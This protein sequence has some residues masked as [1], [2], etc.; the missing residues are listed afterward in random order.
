[1]E[2]GISDNWI[3]VPAP[4]E[5]RRAALD[6]VLRPLA[7]DDRPRVIDQTLH[8]VA[9][10]TRSLDGLLIAR[11]GPRL[12]GAV[13]AEIQP[14]RTAG[15]W[16]PQVAAAAS[17]AIASELLAHAAAY[18]RAHRVRM[19]QA[20]LA[21]D[22]SAMAET[23]RAADFEHLTDLLYLVSG[24][25]Q[26]PTAPVAS[27]LTF[28]PVNSESE[29]RLAA[30]VEATYLQTLDCPRLNGL[31]ECRDVLAGYRDTAHGDTSHWFLVRSGNCDVG[32]LLLARHAEI[33]TWEVIY[34]G[35][36][37]AARGA[38]LGAEVARQ[39]Q[40]LVRAAGGDRLMLAVDAANEPAIKT[41][42][43]AGF[44]TFDRRRVFVRFFDG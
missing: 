2:P 38:G 23:L 27:G 35:L 13:W 30:I 26:F 33:D 42:A 12:L 22:A 4:P 39:A 15:V 24:T 32:C 25:G 17:H 36:T 7:P 37:P 3:V 14:G 9:A 29:E 18:L 21:A 19:A 8:A 16:P 1:M 28:E 44:V 10:G 11:R 41:Y 31:R 43:A 20:L 34:M 5:C 40:W 6:L